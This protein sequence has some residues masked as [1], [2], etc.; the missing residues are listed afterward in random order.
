MARPARYFAFQLARELGILDPD[1]LL[2]SISS[3]KLSE[4]SEFI[5]LEREA[6]HEQEMEQTAAARLESR[7][8]LRRGSA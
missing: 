2:R 6:E 4:W 7:R 3:R 8:S 1:R 5:R